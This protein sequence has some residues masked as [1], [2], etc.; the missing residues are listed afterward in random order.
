[1][2]TSQDNLLLTGLRSNDTKSLSSLYSEYYA[3]VARYIKQ[4]SGTDEDAEDIFQEAIVVLLQKIKKPEFTLT[5]P[6][7]YFLLAISKNLWL[8]RLRT[9][10]QSTTDT[11][12]LRENYLFILSNHDDD[13][14]KTSRIDTWLQNI[15]IHCQGI[16]KAL[17]FYNEPMDRLMQKMGWKNKHTASNQ[18]YK[19]LEQL[20]KTSE[21]MG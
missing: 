15:T 2:P 18:K 1:M 6:L 11:N 21:E 10:K 14:V 5:A 17:F 19:C 4:N 13:G 12:R 3:V 16:L 20:K 8:K 9:H 7:K